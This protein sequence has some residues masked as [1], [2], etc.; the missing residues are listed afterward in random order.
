MSRLATVSLLTALLLCRPSPSAAGSPAAE[1]GFGLG[2]AVLNLVYIPMKAVVAIGGG[3]VG[4]V[5]GLLTGGDVRAA[6][7]VWVP[8]GGGSY[9]VR[10]AHLEGSEQLEFFGSDY[11]DTPST[12][13]EGEARVSYDAMYESR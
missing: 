6:Y 9:F 4:A 8:T 5:T 10:A 3:V 12:L 13:R 1:V 2:A 11:A 7:S